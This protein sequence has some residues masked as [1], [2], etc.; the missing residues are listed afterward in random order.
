MG[1][2]QI[3][4]LCLS[5]ALFGP[6]SF[7]HAYQLN[8][9]WT[10][11]AYSPSGLVQGSP[12]TISW[13][14]IPDGTATSNS[15]GSGESD[16]IANLDVWFGAGPGGA[17]LTQ[18]PWFA[19]FSSSFDRF[20]SIS[21][22]SYIYESA[23]DGVAQSAANIG[24]PGVRSDVRIGG[25]SIDGPSNIL[26]FNNFP[27]YG[28]MVID[29]DDGST[30]GLAVNNFRVFRNTIQH[31]HGHGI[32]LNHVVSGSRKFLM[33]PFIQAE[34]DGLQFD[35]LLGVQRHYGDFYEKSNGGLG[36][37]TFS[38]ATPLGSLAPGSMLSIG[39]NGGDLLPVASTEVD[40][41]SIDD[42]SD[43]DFYTFTIDAPAT[44]N[45]TL[46]P[47]GATYTQ[48]P[49]GGS[50]ATFVTSELSDL[51]LT[52]LD[53]DGTSVLDTQNVNGLGVAETITNFSLA[54]AGTYYTRI[55]GSAD[56]IQ[57][58]RLDISTTNSSLAGDFN[59]DGIFDCLD[60]DA[61]TE[62]VAGGTN[63]IAFDLNGDS[64]V[65][66]T[67]VDEWL[68][69]AGNANLA[70]QNPYLHGDANLDGV[71]DGSDLVIWN[72]HKFTSTAAWCQGDFNSDGSI[73]GQDFIIWNRNKFLSSDVNQV[74][75]P[76]AAIGLAM[77][78]LTCWSRRY[79]R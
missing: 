28:D 46:T 42:D 74:P 63:P 3:V 39:V 17:D 14:F 44:V 41:V 70:S 32:G 58:Y 2:F 57:L 34:F 31:E 79:H 29:T 23:D 54:A 26:A 11:T 35:D 12:T 48:G 10:S 7:S 18:R 24:I 6:I 61:L 69:I 20:S 1:R 64:I 8:T 67:D 68:S 53:T 40:F 66:T 56:Q 30:Y 16:L 75:E 55:N 43:T 71:V 4:K 15:F 60:V 9:R 33:E 52:L 38:N 37:E 47:V 5:A 22:L 76:G 21:G 13:G 19:F 45:L 49:Q 62:A 36:N 27:D 50:Q 73:D 77:G 72:S 25:R 59:S 65:S 51:S 78:M